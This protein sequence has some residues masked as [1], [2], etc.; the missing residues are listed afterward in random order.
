LTLPLYEVAHRAQIA[1]AELGVPFEEEIIDLSTPRTAEYLE[2]NPRGLVPSLRFGDQIITES[3]IVAQLLADAYPDA[4]ANALL[5][6]STSPGGALARARIAFFT[7]TWSTKVGTF[8]AKTLYSAK[9]PEEAAASAAE[10]NAAIVKE[11]E[12]LL[13]GA[14]PFFAGSQKLTLAEVRVPCSSS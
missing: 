1:L 11:I 7:D 9:S 8:F 3:A 14:A 10:L 5:P 6:A 4:N 12:P 13:A 2:V